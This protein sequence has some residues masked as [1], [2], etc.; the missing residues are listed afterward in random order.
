MFMGENYAIAAALALLC[1]VPC[2]LIQMDGMR[3]L[4]KPAHS[5]HCAQVKP[6]ASLKHSIDSAGL[7]GETWKDRK[8]RLFANV[9]E[10]C[11]SVDAMKNL[12]YSAAYG[13]VFQSWKYPVQPSETA[14]SALTLEIGSK[15]G[16]P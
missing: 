4:L 14:A 10:L 15:V 7:T 1:F 2:G 8:P 9:S 13:F 12:A 11:V 6:F 5:L 16:L 3:S